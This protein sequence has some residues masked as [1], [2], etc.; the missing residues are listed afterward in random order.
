M[1]H[2]PSTTHQTIRITIL[3]CI[4]WVSFTAATALIQLPWEFVDGNPIPALFLKGGRSSS[5]FQGFVLSLMA[6]FAGA[7][8]SLMVHHIPWIASACCYLSVISMTSAA[9]FFSVLAVSQVH[10]PGA[11]GVEGINVAKQ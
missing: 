2:D 9:V 3:Q 10:S 8:S 4:I 11:D 1:S 7:Y 6:A 5:T